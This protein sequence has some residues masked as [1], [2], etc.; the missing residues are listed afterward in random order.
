MKLTRRSLLKI[1]IISTA[2]I[3]LFPWDTTVAPS[4]TIRVVDEA[5]NPVRGMLVKQIWRDWSVESTDH[6]EYLRTDKDGYVVTPRRSIRAPLLLRMIGATWS[7]VTQGMH[8][9]R[10]PHVTIWAYGDDPYMWSF[11]DYS[12]GLPMPK[13]IELQRH[14]TVA[15]P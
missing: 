7:F 1:L 11:I 14:Q 9:S 10:G 6:Y 15:Y 2:L 5:S 3:L 8:S 13:Q 4:A 12:P